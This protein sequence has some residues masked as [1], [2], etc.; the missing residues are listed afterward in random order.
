VLAFR[1]LALPSR[2]GLPVEYEAS[3]NARTVR[4]GLCFLI[5]SS[6]PPFVPML[7]F[8]AVS[9]AGVFQ[10]WQLSCIRQL[11][12]SG[13]AQLACVARTEAAPESTFERFCSKLALPFQA[14]AHVAQIFGNLPHIEL[15][16]PGATRILRDLQ[17]DFILLFAQ[18]SRVP[19]ITQAAKF[20]AWY[21][22]HGDI[23]RFLS[24]APAF[25]EVY[26]N[27]PV[28]VATLLKA[29]SN[30]AAGIVLKTGVLPT[31]P[32]SFAENAETLFSELPAW[33]V[34]V[35]R[36]ITAGT[37]TYFN[38]EVV[39]L[40]ASRYG[41]PHR[42]QFLA[43]RA[44]ERMNRIARY[45]RIKLLHIDWNVF[46]LTGSPGDFIGKEARAEVTRI[47]TSQSGT[48]L[49]DPCVLQRNGKTYVFCEEYRHESLRGVI[50]ALETSAEQLSH[51]RVIIEHPYH[52][53]YPQ[54]L[55]H[56]GEVY[57]VAETASTG[58]IGL[59]RAIEF[60]YHWEY[61]R[62]LISGFRAIDSTFLRYKGK[63]WLFCTSGDGPRRGDHSHLHIWYAY[64]LLGE[65]QPHPKNPVK[66][67]VRS[68]RPGGQ[69]FTQDGRLYRP[70]QDCSGT[71]GTAIQINRV[72]VLTEDD[73]AE[74]VVGT[75]RP[76]A[77]GYSKGIHTISAAG[78]WCIVDAKRYV[79]NPS[80][81]IEI[82]KDG[83]KAGLR[84][85]GITPERY[86]PRRVA[87]RAG[88]PAPPRPEETSLRKP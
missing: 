86:W 10:S 82:C 76:P 15:A 54:I 43:L 49:A 78:A 51:P 45:T 26:C 74:T 71:Y 70:A 83:I 32:E 31:I 42:L 21:F 18:P 20:G 38:G 6:R 12:E 66:I 80:G 44:V 81:L 79:F 8:A 53:S 69:F 63:W 24:S 58:S 1:G 11:E 62:A 67:D 35:C 85:C 2:A 84:A 88:L 3:V 4:Q 50:V 37:A 61:V 16:A 33:P 19:E 52:A 29:D 27:H 46:R 22:A 25:W 5:P 9:A 48:Y 30:G 68:S 56:A 34:H 28:T 39:P 17:L 41:M 57:C 14:P 65:W 73:F 36:D 87:V 40:P 60:P 75:I 64:D 13:L 72:D 77:N 23:T 55:Q 7:K 59:Y 47:C